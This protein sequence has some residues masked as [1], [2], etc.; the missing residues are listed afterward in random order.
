MGLV[1]RKRSGKI[2]AGSKLIVP[3][4]PVLSAKKFEVT[5]DKKGSTPESSQS[6]TPPP[7]TNP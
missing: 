4:Q 7:P 2:I 1:N 5:F 6:N 3:G